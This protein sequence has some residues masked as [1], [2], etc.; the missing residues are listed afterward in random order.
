MQ[1]KVLKKG[2]DFQQ[3]FLSHLNRNHHQRWI[4]ICVF[5]KS[6]F[7]MWQ[8]KKYIWKVWVI[9]FSDFKIQIALGRCRCFSNGWCSWRVDSS[10]SIEFLILELPGLEPLDGLNKGDGKVRMEIFEQRFVDMNYLFVFCKSWAFLM[11]RE[12]WFLNSG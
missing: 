12:I 4:H 7:L 9:R 6:W 10:P 1:P 2:V 11:F 3:C 8:I 5:Q